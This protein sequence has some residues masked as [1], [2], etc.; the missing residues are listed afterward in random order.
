M[1]PHH[2]V[3][4]ANRRRSRNRDQ[5]HRGLHNKCGRSPETL[6]CRF[7]N[8]PGAEALCPCKAPPVSSC[9]STFIQGGRSALVAPIGM[10][11]VYYPPNLEYPSCYQDEGEGGDRA[12]LFP[13][14]RWQLWSRTICISSTR[15]PVHN[16]ASQVPPYVD[17]IRNSRGVTS[18]GPS[19][20]SRWF[21]CPLTVKPNRL[22]ETLHL[23]QERQV[24]P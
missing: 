18:R 16:A 1:N 24:R 6:L 23:P 13:Q 3:G 4:Q 19:Q 5:L 15:Q 22:L 7:T 10:A 20:P 8:C 9:L 12:F 2:Q 14:W 17:K 21:C 11:A